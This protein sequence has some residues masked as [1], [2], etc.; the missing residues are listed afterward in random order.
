[1]ACSAANW[2]VGPPP[3]LPCLKR[4]A[5]APSCG[6]VPTQLLPIGKVP[7][8]GVVG[9]LWPSVGEPWLP[10]LM[11]LGGTN[12]SLPRACGAG[13]TEKLFKSSWPQFLSSGSS[14]EVLILQV[15]SFVS[16]S[17][18]T[19]DKSSHH[20]GVLMLSA[21]YFIHLALPLRGVWADSP[22]GTLSPF[23][24]KQGCISTQEVL[25]V[26]FE[27]GRGTDVSFSWLAPV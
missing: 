15:N 22:M 14:K 21:L 9:P 8:D 13:G 4:S 24:P 11:S 19:V 17:L 10:N 23:G 7:R 6:I 27:G 5:V 20:A 2:M 25:K 16:H 26:C 1:M 3:T 18:G 12:W